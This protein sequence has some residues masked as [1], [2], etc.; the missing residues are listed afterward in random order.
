MDPSRSQIG[1]P[2]TAQRKSGAGVTLS[3][4]LVLT[5]A[6]AVLTGGV[7]SELQESR[8]EAT[9]AARTSAVLLGEALAQQPTLDVAPGDTSRTMLLSMMDRYKPAG[10][11]AF[12]VSES[13]TLL[14]S[15]GE[16]DQPAYEAGWLN[17]EAAPGYRL[18]IRGLPGGA[19]V[20]TAAPAAPRV[21]VLLPYAGGALLII[22][23]AALIL[24]RLQRFADEA[25]QLR[26]D[27][28]LL[29][30]R[31]RAFEA[32]G[33]GLWNVERGLLTIGAPIRKALGFADQDIAVAL[34]ELH[35]VFGVESV[36]DATKFLLGEASDQPARL[37]LIDAQGTAHPALFRSDGRLDGLGGVLTLLPDTPATIMT[38]QS[39]DVWFDRLNEA[40]AAIPQAFVHWDE[41]GR[42][43]AWNNQFCALF[44]IASGRLERGQSVMDVAAMAGIDGGYLRRHFA[45][46]TLP[47]LE[48]EAVF[49]GDRSLRIF[50]KRTFADG[51]LYIGQDITEAKVETEARARKER[52]LQMTVHILEQSRRELSELNERYALER[53]RAEDAN[54]AKTEFLANISHEL[55]TPLNAINGFS[56]IMQSEL[57][58][59]L[60]SEKYVEYVN[61]INDSGRHLL[62]LID[63]I[64]DLSKV[65]AGKMELR[66]NPVDLEKILEESIRVIEPQSRAGDVKLHAA[67]D[68]LPSVFADARAVKQVLLNLLSNATKFT[69]PGGKV[70]LTTV[71][72]LDSVTVIIADTGQGI[73]SANVKRLGT[74]F[75]NFVS[76]QKRDKRGTGLGLALSKS[77]IEAMSG[78]LCIASEKGRGTVAAFTLPRRHGASVCLPDILD[79]KVYVLT[80]S[81]GAD[82]TQDPRERSMTMVAE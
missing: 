24:R 35:L 64:L 2:G 8:R 53:Q 55:R 56:A 81:Q 31:T 18:A 58:G 20:V 75:V 33:V 9:E 21:G 19:T 10:G 63:D 70:T 11:S 37:T 16:R 23:G 7:I 12:V 78:I 48:E 4:V 72:D 54:R 79:G 69:E 25:D 47:R 73:E 39:D 17:G 51:W 61:D 59:S 50:C 82:N 36:E 42:L 43:V 27:R 62:E 68:H 44:R 5:A 26:R 32:S 30:L 6:A 71:S 52:E 15:V 38:D 49:P 13:R 66:L 65:E 57:Y 34:D 67:F 22:F 41:D 76:A 1:Q 29:L 40:L 74:P 3:V 80:N 28:E 45:P 60:G 77:L 14:M 46:T